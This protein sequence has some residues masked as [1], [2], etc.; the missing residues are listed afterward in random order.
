M[1]FYVKN[2]TKGHK[3]PTDATPLYEKS[4]KNPFRAPPAN[5]FARAGAVNLPRGPV[6]AKNFLPD[7]MISA[8]NKPGIHMQSGTGLDSLPNQTIHAC[9]RMCMRV[10]V[11]A[12]EYACGR[13]I[14]GV[15]I[16]TIVLADDDACRQ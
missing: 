9:G 15:N 6:P 12:D 2:H 10:N 4:H 13:V 16:L 7:G 1:R 11:H 3:T 5:R 8:N 14:R